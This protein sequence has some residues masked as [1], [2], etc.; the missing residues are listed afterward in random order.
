MDSV[1]GLLD[2]PRA[3][4]AFVLRSVMRPPW[5]LRI[6]DRAP[7]TVVAMA[8][9]SAHIQPDSAPADVLR[10]GDVAVL[11]GPDAYTIASEE[12]IAP[13][14]VIHPGQRCTTVD[15]HELVDIASLGMRTWGN[16]PAGQVVM[17][18][19]TY[20]QHHEIGRHLFAALPPL[21]TLRADQWDQPL[22]ALVEREATFDRPGQEAVLDRL[23]DLLLVAG[24]REWFAGHGADEPGWYR[25]TTDPVVGKA[26]RL[27]QNAPSRPW[28]VG[29]LAAATGVSRAVFAR[30]FGELAGQPPMTF[31]TTWR[32]DL[33]ADLL[34]EPEATLAS[35][36]RQ[37][38]YANPFA[39][40]S[41]FKRVRGIS[42]QQHRAAHRPSN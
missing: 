37:V 6:Q 40:S 4:G 24:L 28:T 31:L 26:V 32:L 11:R 33:A 21:V 13:Q 19:G 7:L 5:S 25:A 34:L 27:M 8:A 30:R 39:L 2:G 42:P 1:V 41:A 20:T 12:G 29:N 9:G 35:V 16:D 15:G 18:T 14:A 17:I 3:R 38:G 22:V 36:A 23:L 10:P